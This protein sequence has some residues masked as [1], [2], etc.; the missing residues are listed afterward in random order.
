MASVSWVGPKNPTHESVLTKAVTSVWKLEVEYP[1]GSGSKFP[2]M[3][4]TGTAWVVHSYKGIGTFWVTNRH[5]LEYYE[6]SAKGLT[7]HAFLFSPINAGN[8]YL[9]VLSVAKSKQ[10]DIAVL[11]T[12][13]VADVPAL[14][15]NYQQ[16]TF[17]RKVT[18]IGYGFPDSYY[19]KNLASTNYPRI[20]SGVLTSSITE[21][22]DGNL[23]SGVLLHS[24]PIYH[25]NSGGPLLDTEANVIGMD[26]GYLVD[27]SD[28]F[29]SSCAIPVNVVA[30]TVNDLLRAIEVGRG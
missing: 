23:V 26:E 16:M 3:T 20:S 7:K 11:K 2:S 21:R 17:G 29:I 13:Y 24:N 1:A 4:Y 18:S 6:I 5:V 12:E 27:K 28:G 25:G 19:K 14:R 15:F 30:N 10:V 22:M 8:G 9:K